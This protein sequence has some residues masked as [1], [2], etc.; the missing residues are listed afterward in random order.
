MQQNAKTIC[1]KNVL[2][3]SN[4]EGNFMKLPY[5]DNGCR[6]I[7]KILKEYLKTLFYSEVGKHVGALGWD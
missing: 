3:S 6:Q 5:L 1:G 7:A 2:K 4:F